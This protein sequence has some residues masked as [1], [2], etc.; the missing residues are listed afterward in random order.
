MNIGEAARASG[1]SAKM[2]RYYEQT[3]L[4]QRADR[5]DGGYRHYGGSDVHTL[6][7]IRRSRDLGFSVEQIAALL[8]LWR[9]RS[10]ASGQVK[11]LALDHVAVL[12][13]KIADLEA[14][15]RTLST[16]AESCGGGDRPHCPII[17]DLAGQGASHGPP[18]AKPAKF[19]RID[20]RRRPPAPALP[21]TGQSS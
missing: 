4:I 3:G 21:S 10:R 13:G 12:K 17:D 19:G 16:L 15:V 7:F 9:D 6:A 8:A 1:I 14:M 5:S 18:K 20:G 2:I 11:A